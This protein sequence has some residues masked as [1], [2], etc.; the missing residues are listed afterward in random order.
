MI[1]QDKIKYYQERIAELQQQFIKLKVRLADKVLTLGAEF[2]QDLTEIV[3]KMKDFQERIEK[4][5]TE[6]RQK[7]Q[8]R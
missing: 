8:E 5:E 3:K 7:K 6:K 2:N 1:K 4:L